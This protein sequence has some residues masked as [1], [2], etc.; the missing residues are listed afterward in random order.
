MKK[1]IVCVLLTLIM[2]VSLVPAAALTASAA[3]RTT[4]EAAITVLKQME[5]YSKNCAN[6]YIGYGTKCPDCSL[7]EQGGHLMYEKEADKQLREVLADLDKAVN[8]FASKNGLSLTQGQHDALV[9]FSFENG[10]AWTAGTGEFQSAVKSGATGTKF[11]NAICLWESNTG[12]DNRRMVEANMYLN[13]AYSS[14][15]PS[16]FVH[17]VFEPNGGTMTASE[18]QYFDAATPQQITITPVKAGDVFLGWYR[19]GNFKDADGNP[20]T[21]EVRVSHVTTDHK[22]TG[23]LHARWQNEGGEQIQYTISKSSLASNVVYSSVN[24]GKVTKYA[25]IYDKEVK[26]VLGNTLN[27]IDDQI[28]EDGVR[29]ARIADADGAAMGWVKLKSTGSTAN[30]GSTTAAEGVIVTVT[31]SYVN[32]RKNAS[33]T[34]TKNGSFTQGTELVIIDTKNGK[35]GF[36]WGQ[37]AKSAADSTPIGWVALMYTNYESVKNSG[38]TTVAP[39]NGSVV[40]TAII[41]YPGYVNLRS[42]AGTHN[43]IVGSLANGFEVDLYETKFVNG[44]QWGRCSSGWFCLIYADVTGLVVNKNN[45]SDVGYATYVF[46]GDLDDSLVEDKTPL[47]EIFRVAPNGDMIE[48]EKDKKG[49]VKVLESVDVTFSNLINQ[50]GETW[51]KTSYGWI[52]MSKITMDVA[53]FYVIAENLTVRDNYDTSAD[54]VDVLIKGTE[55]DVSQI[56]LV[57]DTI[58]GYANKVGEVEDP[59]YSGWV[60][61]ANKNVSRNGMPTVDTGSDKETASTGKIATVVNT[62]SVRVR[63]TGALSGTVLGSLS[64]GTSAAVLEENDGWYNLDIDVDDNPK[65]GSWVY[66]QYLEI[67]TG[68]VS[69]G[70]SSGSTGTVETG[71]GIVANTY[72]GVNVRTGAGVGN[73]AVGKLLPGTVVEILE[74]KTHGASKWGRTAEGWVCM[75][76]ITMVDNYVPAGS[77]TGSTGSSNSTSTSTSVVAIYTGVTNEDVNIYKTP[78]VNAEFVREGVPAGY[79]VTMH[80]IVTVTEV[81]DYEEN[82]NETTTV[83]TKT[84]W[85]RVNEGYIMNPEENI[86]LTAEDESIYTVTGSDVL[87]VRA[88]AGTGNDIV[89]KLKKGDQV[90]VNKYTII[91]NNIWGHIETDIVNNTLTD[92]EGNEVKEYWEGEGWVSL[93]YMSKGAIT[94]KT[95]SNNTNTGNT[96][97]GNTDT[98]APII[99]NTGNTTTGGFVNNAGG[100]KYTGK[101][102]NANEVNVRATASTTASI[103]TKLKN[104]AA[105]V[106][107]ETTISEGMA[108][109]RCDAGWVYLYYVDLTPC[110]N[111]AVD[112]RVVYNDNTIVY[113]DMNCSDVAGTYSKM[114]VIDIYEIVGKMART[115][116]GWVSTD[117]LL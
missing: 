32:M 6:G 51:V 42:D 38:T 39:S 66:G 68:T 23:S 40:A 81:T 101:V 54:R 117:N 59:T 24:G 71:K 114:S 78:S 92:E 83:E 96:N 30:T 61:L 94:I 85:A 46:T 27:V 52:E 64:R 105:L 1:R 109:G 43:Q 9:L 112:A 48:E 90:T 19:T 50:D 75:D 8:S 76:Y 21:A 99:G 82:G 108:W 25:N 41:T 116:L 22:N 91:G 84:H 62:D 12:D 17:L 69:S 33:I 107:Y 74:V 97:T 11:L 103:T 49:N 88:D 15:A 29:W 44:V 87:N 10:T 37:V 111:G 100:Y 7:K 79:P 98:T 57:G 65:T 20:Y 102:I 95:E 47:H 63:K 93:S 73:A 3:T 36:L 2:L 106:V 110:T 104:G 26:I 18:H 70:S 13:G 4:S 77:A 80:E 60:N 34:S 5:G 53:K 45:I 67:T 86:T 35:D 55:F 28:D 16:R 58:W 31:N 14:T 113:T 89:H 115:E 56:V 72:A